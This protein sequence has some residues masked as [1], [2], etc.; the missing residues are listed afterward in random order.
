MEIYNR[1]KSQEIVRHD[2]SVVRLKNNGHWTSICYKNAAGELHRE[3]GPA[4]IYKCNRTGEVYCYEYAKNGRPH[5]IGGVAVMWRNVEGWARVT[6]W[7]KDRFSEFELYR[8][9]GRAI[10]SELGEMMRE[11]NI[12]SILFQLELM[13]EDE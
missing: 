12:E 13:E 9:E 7:E 1:I 3:D 4:K 6:G 5:R 11:D 8:Y 2:G 10:P